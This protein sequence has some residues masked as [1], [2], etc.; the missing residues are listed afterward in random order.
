MPNIYTGAVQ[1]ACICAGTTTAGA[2]TG[3]ARKVSGGTF[4]RNPSNIKNVGIGGQLQV[5]KGTDEVSLEL[6]CVGVAKTTLAYWFPTTAGVVVASFPNMLV[7][8]DDG[9]NG[10]ELVLAYGQP[11]NA[12]ISC[13]ENGQIEYTLGM[14]FK[15]CTEIAANT[16]APVYLSTLGH[17]QN[18][19]AV[20]YGT[21]AYGTNN[22]TLT[23]DTGCTMYN[24]ADG[25]T[26]GSQTV[27]T[28]YVCTK[29]TQDAKFE[30]A[31]T[32]QF[33]MAGMDGDSW[34][35][36]DIVLALANGV[37]AEN[38]TITLD[39]WVPDGFTMPLQA[40]GIVLFG[41]TFVPGSGTTYNRVQFA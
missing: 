12:T 38:I 3:F 1:G 28:G 36:A 35:A 39:G 24:T 41:H 16:T 37:T 7:E 4:S 17:S 14:K 33:K 5:L 15:T 9:T 32:D 30:A 6:T 19:I 29:S 27:P 18:Q 26:A 11:S 20:T 23:N 21:T 10:Q 25:K 34:T 40:D 31:L 13:Q 22:F 2:L 8:V